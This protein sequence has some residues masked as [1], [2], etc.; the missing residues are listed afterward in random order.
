MSQLRPGSLLVAQDDI[1]DAFT[2]ELLIRNGAHMMYLERMAGELIDKGHRVVDIT[3][4]CKFDLDPGL[5]FVDSDGNG[6]LFVVRGR[7]TDLPIHARRL[8]AVK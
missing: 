7:F 8:V 1:T 3:T 4:M 6:T 5:E 2:G